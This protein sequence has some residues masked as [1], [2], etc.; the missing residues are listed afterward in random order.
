MHTHPKLTHEEHY[1]R[2]MLMGLEYDWRDG[3]YFYE[4]PNDQV[5]MDAVTLEVIDIDICLNRLMERDLAV[6]NW[7]TTPTMEPYHV[8]KEKKDAGCLQGG[9]SS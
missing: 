2:A 3:S 6:V 8:W 5:Y 7:N 9:A 1:T 4:V